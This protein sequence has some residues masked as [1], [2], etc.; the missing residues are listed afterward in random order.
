MSLNIKIIAPD[1][2]VW[3]AKAEEIILPS[4]TGQ[5]GILTGH[6][7]LL[8]ALDI[9]VMRVRIQ[10]E[11]IPIVLLGGFAEIESNEVIILVNGAEEIADINLEK[12]KVLLETAQQT[13]QD[14][15]TNK[16]KI[17]ATQN[18]RKAR[19]RVQA[20]TMGKES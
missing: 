7:P 17:E 20:I 14:A 10:K 18:I 11:W 12:S 5:L 13:L 1:K 2:T 9:G 15:K 16:D 4:S 6:A 19:A 8:T 3:D